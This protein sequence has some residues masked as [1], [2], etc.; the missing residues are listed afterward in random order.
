MW[1]ESFS[2]TGRGKTVYGP[3]LCYLFVSGSLAMKFTRETSLSILQLSNF[4][5]QVSEELSE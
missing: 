3:V 1:Q 2:V 4:T 5:L